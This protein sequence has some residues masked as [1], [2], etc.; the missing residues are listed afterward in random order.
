[1]KDLS[2]YDQVGILFPGSVLLIGLLVLFP[3]FKPE[4]ATGGIS[5]GDFGLFLVV[6]YVLGHLLAS[7]GDL[8]ERII[9]ASDG[10]LPGTWLVK[11][12]SNF[13]EPGGNARV[14]AKL[15]KRLK[16]E[17]V[18]AKLDQDGMQRYF[19]QIYRDALSNEA[20]ISRIPTFNGIYGLCRGVA[21]ALLI[22]AVALP[23]LAFFCPVRQIVHWPYWSAGLAA[24]AAIFI[25]RMRKFG[26]IFAKEV[27]R[28]FTQLPDDPSP[29]KK[30]GPA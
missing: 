12:N 16:I 1:M 23:I 20:G 2:F 14:Q 24:V 3:E 19:W 18:I 15:A 5:I 28:V 29:A 21:V 4:F 8:L 27:Y 13:L 6:A 26:Q 25:S 10:G 11:K 17:V 30:S 22:L 7:A 9:W